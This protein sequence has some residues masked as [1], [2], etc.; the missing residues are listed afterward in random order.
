M[1]DLGDVNINMG[2]DEEAQ[3]PNMQPSTRTNPG[4]AQKFIVS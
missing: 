3:Q 1:N 2:G 4:P